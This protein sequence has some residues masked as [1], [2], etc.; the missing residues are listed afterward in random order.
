MANAAGL[1]LFAAIL[2]FYALVVTLVLLAVLIGNRSPSTPN[3]PVCAAALRD[4]RVLPPDDP[5]LANP[6][7]YYCPYCSKPGAIVQSGALAPG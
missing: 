1:E 6:P 2:V 5:R 4:V 3:C 7:D